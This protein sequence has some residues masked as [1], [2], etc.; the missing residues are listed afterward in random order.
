MLSAIPGIAAAVAVRQFTPYIT[1]PKFNSEFSPEK[2]PGP[3]GEVVPT[4][5][6]QGLC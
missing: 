1:P 3:N 2:L 4:T 5:M 6:F